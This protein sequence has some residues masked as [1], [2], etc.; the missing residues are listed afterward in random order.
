V[1]GAVRRQPATRL[2]ELA[3]A[4][5]PLAAA[6]LVPGDRDMHE[7]LEELALGRLG[8][9]PRILQFLVGGEELAGPN[10]PQAA[11]KG[12]RLRP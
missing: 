5:D 8:G 12:I 7:T 2:F 11:L 1:P 9:A 10:Q 6:G 3:F 4:P